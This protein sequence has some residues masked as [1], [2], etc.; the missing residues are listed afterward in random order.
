MLLLYLKWKFLIH[1]WIERVE[2]FKN[3]L[4]VRLRTDHVLRGISLILSILAHDCI[5][6][7]LKIFFFSRYKPAGLNFTL[8]QM[9]EPL[10]DMLLVTVSMVQLFHAFR[11]IKEETHTDHDKLRH[12]R[13]S[14]LFITFY[15][16]LLREQQVLR[17]QRRKYA[18]VVRKKKD[19]S[20]YGILLYLLIIIPLSYIIFKFMACAIEIMM[21]LATFVNQS[22]ALLAKQVDQ[23]A[24]A[25]ESAANGINSTRFTDVSSPLLNAYEAATTS[26]ADDVKY[27]TSFFPG[28][29]EAFKARQCVNAVIGDIRL[30]EDNQLNTTSSSYS[31]EYSVNYQP[32][33]L[34][35]FHISI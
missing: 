5:F 32:N 18:D 30:I 25:F 1:Q 9:L 20:Y 22:E 12:Y 19:A 10:F 13:Y 34:Y 4:T 26:A 28:I 29:L 21:A 16:F 24:S 31:F 14:A 15:P 7:V 27:Y 33:P 11:V 3:E 6:K 8:T 17:Y 35:V 2:T 23:A